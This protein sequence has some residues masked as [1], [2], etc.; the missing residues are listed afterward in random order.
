MISLVDVLDWPAFEAAH[1]LHSMSTQELAEIEIRWVHSSEVADIAELLHGGELLLTAGTAIRKAS[2]EALSNYL[3]SLAKRGIAALAVETVNWTESARTRLVESAHHAH[4]SLLELRAAAPFVD[5]AEHINSM[6]VNKQARM[7]VVVDELSRKLSELISSSL[8]P[9][10]TLIMDVIAQ[11]LKSDAVLY[12][13]SGE[14]LAQS[15]SRIGAGTTDGAI[16]ELRRADAVVVIAG[17]ITARLELTATT[18][19]V[20]L[21]QSAASRTAEVL[22]IA[23]AH[24]LRPSSSHAAEQRLIRAIIDDALY[25]T[26]ASLWGRANVPVGPFIT[27]VVRPF[28]TGM[29]NTSLYTA[30]RKVLGHGAMD[31]VGTDLIGVFALPAEGT[32]AARE[33]FAATLNAIATKIPSRAVVGTLSWNQ[34][35]AHLSYVD[36][37]AILDDESFSNAGLLDAMSHYS[38]RALQHLEN[39]YFSRGFLHAQIEPLRL[40]DEKHGTQLIETLAMWLDCACN[41]TETAALLHIERQTMHKRLAK[42]FELLEGDPRHD[43]DLL[44][45]HMAVRMFQQRTNL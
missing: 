9:D 23:L 11:T 38:V 43:A 16:K 31:S 5:I 22:S 26:L 40:W 2:A 6:I 37:L 29:L 17:N 19:P 3:H 30:V 27:F 20:E 15:S 8:H 14:I 10:L 21:L 42:I 41:T 36:A 32:R 28:N 12:D 44:G 25:A 35:F 4:V 18:Q 39:Q 1:P 7:H 33:K 24:L 13:H 34:T 45:L